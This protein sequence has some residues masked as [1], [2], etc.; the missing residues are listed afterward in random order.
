MSF[1]E[2]PFSV[3]HYSDGDDAVPV[4]TE[5]AGKNPGVKGK[6]NNQQKQ[7]KFS[8]QSRLIRVPHRLG[9]DG[10]GEMDRGSENGN[11]FYRFDNGAPQSYNGQS[12]GGKDMRQHDIN[13]Y[14]QNRQ[15]NGYDDLNEEP[16]DG[17]YSSE[18]G[19]NF[20]GEKRGGPQRRR[21]KSWRTN[22]SRLGGLK[23]NEV[24]KGEKF[25]PKPKDSSD[26]KNVR[27]GVEG[28]DTTGQITRRNQSEGLIKKVQ[29]NMTLKEYEELL[30]QKRKASEAISPAEEESTLD[31]AEKPEQCLDKS[32]SMDFVV[33]LFKR[34]GDQTVDRNR[35]GRQSGGGGSGSGGQC[36]QLIPS[37]EGC[38]ENPP[39]NINI[40]DPEQFPCLNVV[41]KT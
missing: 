37:D 34:R 5:M 1:H 23:L 33:K 29:K 2:N 31:K 21:M 26:D 25:F 39:F 11:G 38:P 41:I 20:V 6:H 40:Q 22:S 28:E 10:N 17:D 35:V 30:I 4:V 24:V 36:D 9:K 3:L 18:G 13:E 12:K 8:N 32:M 27:V 15:G 7:Q 14:S 16:P 19:W